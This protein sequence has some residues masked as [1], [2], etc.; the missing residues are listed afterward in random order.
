M[1]VLGTAAFVAAL[2]SFVGTALGPSVVW[3]DGAPMYAAGKTLAPGDP[4]TPIVMDWERVEASIDGS[5]EETSLEARV[6]ASF[7]LHNTAGAVR[8]TVG[9]PAHGP[10]FFVFRPK[11]L[12]R[13]FEVL[14]DGGVVETRR[15][16]LPFSWNGRSQRQ[17]VP[18]YIWEMG[19]GPQ[20]VRNVEVSY[21]HI[22]MGIGGQPNPRLYVFH[23]ILTSG[24][25]WK[26]PIGKAEIVVKLPP[27]FQPGQ[28]LMALPSGY[29]VSGNTIAWNLS[30]FEPK[31]DIGVAFM[32]PRSWERLEAA[33]K[34]VAAASHKAD[35]HLRL[36][37]EYARL[38]AHIYPL[39]ES[40]RLRDLAL[41]EAQ[42]ALQHDPQ[43]LPTLLWLGSFHEREARGWWEGLYDDGSLEKALAY[44]QRAAAIAPEDGQVRRALRQAYVSLGRLPLFRMAGPR[45]FPPRRAEP[46]PEPRWLASLDYL[47]KAIALKGAGSQQAYTTDEDIQALRKAIYVNL[48]RF[49]FERGDLEAA[50]GYARSLAPIT[51][52]RW[53]KYGGLSEGLPDTMAS[54]ARA[55]AKQG[56]VD[57]ALEVYGIA[58]QDWY[59]RPP[60][61]RELPRRYRQVK[62]YYWQEVTNLLE[63]HY[64][65]LQPPLRSLT[66]R[67][68]TN[69]PQGEREVSLTLGYAP[70][71]CHQEIPAPWYV[72]KP[73]P[74]SKEPCLPE[75]LEFSRGVQALG[76]G[77]RSEIGPGVVVQVSQQLDDHFAGLSTIATNP[78]KVG[79]QVLQW[80]THT[81]TI[82][83]PFQDPAEFAARRDSFRRHLEDAQ[84][85]AIW[86]L[87]KALLFPAIQSYQVQE[88]PFWTDTAFREE[89]D[90]SSLP[91]SPQAIRQELEAQEA[92]AAGLAPWEL[93][94]HTLRQEF[95]RARLQEA[96]ALFGERLSYSV[97]LDEWQKVDGTLGERVTLEAESRSYHA[98]SLLAAGLVFLAVIGTALVL[99]RWRPFGAKKETSRLG[100]PR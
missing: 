22:V 9:F 19:F 47:D 33:R 3:A 43:H 97:L 51:I 25:G 86:S 41:A 80:V 15:V 37:Q 95:L 91:F 58:L 4:N 30:N 5:P 64:A 52:E 68:T 44:Y 78:G 74:P 100:E 87:L 76:E 62:A 88:N 77:L 2:L 35:S 99:F 21:R 93:E 13:D 8:Q 92:R 53:S 84:P 20:A 27:W 73:I 26:G 18:W 59:P 67:V 7:R 10:N 69:L 94:T 54:L 6:K 57:E 14:V 63:S 72:G 70:R 31:V 17:P 23:Y 45:I 98:G 24:A 28:L 81:V 16:E 42:K 46:P 96:E 48:A 11:D 66:G 1:K 50:L 32:T 36:A 61:E 90:L 83:F 49:A 71:L 85:H 60:G 75:A 38:Q 40:S 34:A 39:T 55:L 12:M 89:I 29:R 79:I 82:R 56:R 65:A